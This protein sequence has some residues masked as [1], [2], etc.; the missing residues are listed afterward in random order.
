MT[1][2]NKVGVAKHT[3]RGPKPAARVFNKIGELD[4]F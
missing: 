4:G 2:D 3:A 1:S